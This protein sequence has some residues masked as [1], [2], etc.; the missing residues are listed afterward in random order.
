MLIIYIYITVRYSF[1]PIPMSRSNVSRNDNEPLQKANPCIVWDNGIGNLVVSIETTYAYNARNSTTRC[2]CSPPS[3]S[4]LL[5][6]RLPRSRVHVNEHVHTRVYTWKVF[7][8]EQ[9]ERHNDISMNRAISRWTTR[10]DRKSR[11]DICAIL[12]K[13]NRESSRRMIHFR[14]SPSGTASFYGSTNGTENSRSQIPVQEVARHKTTRWEDKIWIR[15]FPS[16]LSRYSGYVRSVIYARYN[17]IN[18][19]IRLLRLHAHKD[20]IP[21]L[22]DEFSPARRNIRERP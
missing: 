10:L 12:R 19:E 16:F 4:W 2:V 13:M 21:L 5:C 22:S 17:L 20:L 8:M 9:V 1:L 11:R 18:V 7:S 6:P 14:G 15:A 3:R